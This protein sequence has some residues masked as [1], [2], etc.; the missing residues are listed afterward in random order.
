MKLFCLKE[1]VREVLFLSQYFLLAPKLDTNAKK[2]KET[3]QRRRK[4][5]K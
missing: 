4:K 1:I 5:I 2:E 3:I